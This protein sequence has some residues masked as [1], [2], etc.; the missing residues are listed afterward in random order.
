MPQ[1]GHAAMAYLELRQQVVEGL[2][3]VIRQAMATGDL[4]LAIIA[5]EALGRLLA[6]AEGVAP[7]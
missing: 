7:R 3:N 4:C 5:H 2:S 6:Q 1:L